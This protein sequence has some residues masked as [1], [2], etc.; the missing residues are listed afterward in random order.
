M[1]ASGAKFFEGIEFSDKLLVGRQQSLSLA[2]AELRFEIRDERLQVSAGGGL[3]AVDEE[4]TIEV[5]VLVLNDAGGEIFELHFELATGQI[6]GVDDEFGGASYGAM[7]F[8]QTQAAFFVVFAA[9]FTSDAGVDENELLIFLIGVAL[10]VDHKQSIGQP[11]LIGSQ[12]HTASGVHELEHLL[13]DIADFG[14][15]AHEF[16]GFAS[17]CRVRMGNDLE[18]IHGRYFVKLGAVNP[19]RRGREL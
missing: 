2:I 17:Q 4:H 3:H 19:V 10:R 13:D 14:V 18:W 7:D 6:E 1:E 12:P 9:F 5:I 15:D 11:D 16:A 8:R